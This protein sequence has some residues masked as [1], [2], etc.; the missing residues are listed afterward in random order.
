MTRPYAEVI[1][2]PI[3][4]SKSPLIHNFWLQKLGIDAE[5]RACHVRAEE[6]GDYFAQR[7]KDAEWRGC[8][9]TIP[10]KVHVIKFLDRA[11]SGV[12]D[13]GACNCIAPV[14]GQLVGFNTDTAGIDQAMPGVHD[15]V[16]IIGAGGA[17]RAAIPSLDVMCALDIRILV[18]DPQKAA[19]NLG[20]LDYDFRFFAF[21]QAVEAMSDV[22]G[23][24]NASPLGMVDQPN[25]PVEVLD[26][27]KFTAADAYVFDM[28]YSPLETKLLAEA[29][30][31]RREPIDGLVML[32]AQARS[33]FREFFGQSPADR[34][35]AEL[36]ALLTA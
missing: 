36:R 35:D 17:A 25:L 24:I 14:Q 22:D 5:Y 31:L 6:L 29:R 26:A 9:V 3:A 21:E 12:E 20:H 2:D 18:R 19:S 34:H 27:L 28:V 33:A 32:I 30:R 11:H 7:R 1:G 16:C 13:V 10:H 23:V 4:H 8:N 15:S